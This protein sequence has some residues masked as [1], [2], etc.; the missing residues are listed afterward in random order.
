MPPQ[1]FGMPPNQPF[2]PMMG[3]P[4][5]M[6]GPPG[7]MPPMG[8]MNN[9]FMGGQVMGMNAQFPFMQPPMGQFGQP[10]Q[11]MQPINQKKEGDLGFFEDFGTA[12]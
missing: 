7:M 3:M 12:Q 9:P 2:N 10:M 1:R 6:N 4:P 8:M 11:P 5:M